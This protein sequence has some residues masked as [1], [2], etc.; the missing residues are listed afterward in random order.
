MQLIKGSKPLN[1]R[2]TVAKLVDVFFILVSWHLKIV[3]VSDNSIYYPSLPDCGIE[4]STY[5]S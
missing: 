2:F 1:N 5:L 4:T 3:A